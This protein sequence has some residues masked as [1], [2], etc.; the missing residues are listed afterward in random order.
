MDALD[1]TRRTRRIVGV[2]AV[3]NLAGMI[4]E[5]VVASLIGSVSLFA[6]A[7][8]FAE[9]F[10]INGLVVVALG[11]SASS[12][13]KASV[14]LA[15]LILIPAVAALVTAVLKIVDGSAPEGIPMSVTAALAG[16]VNLAAAA[17]LLRV[18][19]EGS[20][21]VRGAWL[22]ARNDVLGN[23]LILVAGLV[24][25]AWPAIWPDVVVGIV[26]A[27]VNALAAKEVVEQARAEVPELE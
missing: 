19:H 6:D 12:R 17:L 21:L 20:S 16:I 18:R 5:L 13:R 25:L 3:L 4:G 22:A 24:T 26:M 2:V 7:A 27:V 23:L 9:D 11:W 14:W 10:L 1:L 15:G 8:D